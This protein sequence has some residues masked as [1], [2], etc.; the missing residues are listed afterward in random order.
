MSL[1][2][3][4]IIVALSLQHLIPPLNFEWKVVLCWQEPL[5]SVDPTLTGTEWCHGLPDWFLLFSY[6]EF[7]YHSD[8][9]LHPT[10]WIPKPSS[11]RQYWPVSIEVRQ[12]SLE[13]FSVHIFILFLFQRTTVSI[14]LV[15]LFQM[16]WYLYISDAIS[17]DSLSL[18]DYWKP[19][20]Q[21]V[22]FLIFITLDVKIWSCNEIELE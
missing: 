8:L 16:K 18:R 11:E 6:F 20:K 15:I 2:Y 13:C 17:N 19:W 1:F 9:L 7:Y 3:L 10:L 21:R 14:I 12:V 5:I 4:K 22:V